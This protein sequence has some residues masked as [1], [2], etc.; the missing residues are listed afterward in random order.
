M[1]R[2]QLADAPPPRFGV[3]ADLLMVAVQ[4]RTMALVAAGPRFLNG[5]TLMSQVTV[6]GHVAAGPRFLNGYTRLRAY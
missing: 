1:G 2:V 4:A 5:Y 3:G 6:T